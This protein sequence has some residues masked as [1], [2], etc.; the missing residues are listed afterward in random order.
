MSINKKIRRFY[1][2]RENKI[3]GNC[4]LNLYK[5]V[6]SNVK[7][8][9]SKICQ[10]VS[11][12][13][14]FSDPSEIAN[15]FLTHFHSVYNSPSQSETLA[16]DPPDAQFDYGLVFINESHIYHTL[17]KCPLKIN[18]SP[19]SIPFYFIRKCSI[20]LAKPLTFILRFSF[21]HSVLP[22]AWKI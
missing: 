9:N 12:S 7:S 1:I 15:R 4:H 8:K 19:E 5:Y 21:L 2:N 11:D 6:S 14:I 22:S 17:E 16:I 13:Q 3:L 10:I 20:G 18:T